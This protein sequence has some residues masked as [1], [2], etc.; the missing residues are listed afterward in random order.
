MNKNDIVNVILAKLQ[1]IEAITDPVMKHYA[2]AAAYA[3]AKYLAARN[4]FRNENFESI[5]HKA[6]DQFT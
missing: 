5:W 2:T 6:Y 3:D 1:E 4:G